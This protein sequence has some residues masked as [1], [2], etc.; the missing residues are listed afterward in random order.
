MAAAGPTLTFMY[1]TLKRTEANHQVLYSRDPAGVTFLGEGR[2]VDL[3]PLVVTT[4]FNIPFLLHKENTGKVSYSGGGRR[5]AELGPVPASGDHALQH[6]VP[7]A[8]G[9][10]WEGELSHRGGWVEEGRSLD[11]YP[12]VV[13][14]PFNIPFLLHK[15]NTGK[16][17]KATLELLDEFEGHPDFYERRKVKAELLTDASGR[18]VEKSAKQV[19]VW[20]YCLPRFKESLL[21]LPHLSTYRG[22]G[23]VAPEYKTYQPD[24]DGRLDKYLHEL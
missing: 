10:H 7:V 14:T 2:T 9:E 6:P 23:V 19:D 1:G 24:V 12:L 5:G 4:P 13:T 15:E 20:L 11:L 22:D 21:D 16:V 18:C 17:S 3:F 8:Q